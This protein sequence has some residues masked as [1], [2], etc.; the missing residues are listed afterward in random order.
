[1]TSK[2]KPTGSNLGN[3]F[4][5]PVMTFASTQASDVER[6]IAL[7]HYGQGDLAQAESFCRQLTQRYPRDGFGWK[8]LGATL[9]RLDRTS[10]SLEP[11]QVAARLIPG[12]WEIF[13][14]LGVT[15]DALGNAGHAQ[16]CFERALALRPDFLDALRNIAENLRRQ[17][18]LEQALAAY[19][20]VC[21]LEPTN[22]YAR[23]M[24]DTL[25]NQPSERAPDQYVVQVFDDYADSFESHLTNTLQYQVP[26]HLVERLRQVATAPAQGWDVLD[27]GCGT[28]LVGRAI[29]PWAHRLTGVDLSGK[30]IDQARA[31]GCYQRLVCDD[32]VRML[33]QEPAASMDVILAADVFI[34]VGRLDELVSEVH[35]VLR[36]GGHLAFS[37]EALDDSDGRPYKLEPTGRYSQSLAY[38]TSLAQAHAF[39]SEVCDPSVIR[40]EAEHAVQGHLCVWRR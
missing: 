39:T 11:M 23:H 5:R 34:Y 36:P 21:T 18:K 6:E 7:Q 25:G 3:V 33:R 16:A 31:S 32:V 2:N 24:A 14:N 26:Q 17:G 13:N 8:V 19:Q 4:S 29:A 35:R 28:G 40:Q 12:D 38:M 37:I 10:E 9:R 27:L 1:M 22:G 30:M 15:H 20:R